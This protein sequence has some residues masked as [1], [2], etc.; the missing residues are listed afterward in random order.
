MRL[1]RVAGLTLSYARTHSTRVAS[2]QSRRAGG[3]FAD[4]LAAV[5]A[6][7]TGDTGALDSAGLT[8]TQLFPGRKPTRADAIAMKR[9]YHEFTRD[10]L[11]L[12]SSA[13]DH[14]ANTER[15]DVFSLPS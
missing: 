7:S 12:R 11:L 13:G 5:R 4:P 9:E 6:L 10:T 3:V 15:C 2:L 8:S 1:A 14:L